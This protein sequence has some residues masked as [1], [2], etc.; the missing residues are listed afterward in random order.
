MQIVDYISNIKTEKR[1]IRKGYIRYFLPT[2]GGLIF[3]QIAPIVDSLCISRALGDVAVSAMSPVYPIIAIYDM[4][5]AMIGIGGGICMSKAG[6]AGNRTR[7]HPVGDKPCHCLGSSYCAVLYFYGSR[8]KAF[9]CH[10]G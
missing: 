2:M 7:F 6:G 3:T 5:A 4:F 9:K 10:T 1:M 8:T